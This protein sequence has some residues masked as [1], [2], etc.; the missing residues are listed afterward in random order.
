[1]VDKT[2][3]LKIEDDTDGTQNN[4]G[5]TEMN[6]TED[7][8]SVKGIA[9]EN[10]DTTLID[11]AGDGQIQFTDAVNS[12]KKVSDLLDAKQEVF[13]NSTNGF[14]STTTQDAIEEARGDTGILGRTFLIIFENNGNTG[15]KWLTHAA[16]ESTDT[17][18]Y[19]TP[20]DIDVYG[21]SMTNKTTNQDVDIEF[22]K[23]GT[24]PGDLIYTLQVRLGVGERDAYKTM[25]NGGLF[26]LVIGDSI[27]VFVSKVGGD[28]LA[29]PEV[30]VF[31]RVSSNST[32]SSGAL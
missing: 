25:G 3:P 4:F 24:A 5:P 22:Y 19:V 28:T 9:L 20:F 2:R 23:N 31:C 29:S 7:Y 11:K 12:V 6:P 18:P 32:G 21:I 17:L 30:D 15:N 26:S 13:D 8:A 14:V 10:E 16:G 27:S 1:M